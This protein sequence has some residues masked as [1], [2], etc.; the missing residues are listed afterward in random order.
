MVVRPLCS[1]AMVRIFW[2]ILF[3]D[4]RARKVG[5]PNRARISSACPCASANG[6]STSAAVTALRL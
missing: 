1:P 5:S 3:P 4:K 2:A 6:P